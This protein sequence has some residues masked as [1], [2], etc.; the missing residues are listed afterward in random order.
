[1]TEFN[2]REPGYIAMG[3]DIYDAFINSVV[4]GNFVSLLSDAMTT[5]RQLGP[6]GLDLWI[7]SNNKDRNFLRLSLTGDRGKQLGL[8]TC[9]VEQDMDAAWIC[10]ENLMR[11]LRYAKYYAKTKEK[12]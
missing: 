10:L 3:Q 9:F 12:K 8:D 4:S 7:K 6:A 1:M 11:A 2:Y 5:L